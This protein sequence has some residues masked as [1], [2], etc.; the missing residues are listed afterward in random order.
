MVEEKGRG[1]ADMEFGELR[2]GGIEEEVGLGGDDDAG[3]F[4]EQAAE[5]FRRRA[6]GLR[7]QPL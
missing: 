6:T 5:S 1:L 7:A 2:V 4:Q 3:D